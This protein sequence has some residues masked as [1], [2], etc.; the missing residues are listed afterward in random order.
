MRGLAAELRRLEAEQ[1]S[2]LESILESL[3]LLAVQPE[4][5]TEF[6][7]A[8][9]LVLPGWGGMLRQIEQH[10]DRAVRLYARP[11]VSH[12]ISGHPWLAV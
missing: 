12:R 6:L 2:P 11:A 9:L 7:S 10:G 5:W 4:E 3:E 8:T 1:I